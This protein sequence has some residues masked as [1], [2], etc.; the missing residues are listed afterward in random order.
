MTALQP[1]NDPN[2]LVTG[3]GIRPSGACARMRPP[4]SPGY[5]PPVHG[6]AGRGPYTRAVD[7]DERARQL[8]AEAQRVTALLVERGATLVLVFGSFA[9]GDVRRTSDLDIIAVMESDVPFVTRLGELYQEIAPKVGLDLL[10]YTPQEWEEM[11]RRSF[12]RRALREGK[13]LH[14]A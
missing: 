7:R 3:T 11:Q 9:R 10:V 1:R 13:V 4:G 12:V 14:A 8:A 5:A 6:S 2:G